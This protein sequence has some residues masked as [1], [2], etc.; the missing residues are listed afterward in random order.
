M[1]RVEVNALI[2]DYGSVRAVQEVSFVVPEGGMTTMLGPSGCGKTTT[3]RCIAGLETATAGRIVIGARTVFEDGRDRVPVEARNLGMV[4][5]SY[6]IWPHMTIARNVAYGLRMRGRSRDEIARRVG[7]ALAL[8]RLADYGERYPGQLSGGQ[9]QRVV[10]ARALAYDPE[11]LLLDEPLANLDAHLREEMRQELKRIQRETGMTMIAVTHDQSEALAL[12]DQIMVMSHGRVIQ[13]GRPEDV[14]RTPRTAEVAHFLGATNQLPAKR[15]DGRWIVDG[16]GP[17]PDHAAPATGADAAQVLFRPSDVVL[18]PADGG[19]GWPGDVVFAQYLGR[20]VQYLI[21]CGGREITV[22]V[23]SHGG[24]F[25]E[26]APV[27]LQVAPGGL[28]VYPE[29]RA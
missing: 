11:L 7:A 10:L 14:F 4:F 28:F 1:S 22:E 26:G 21:R 6:A 12:S 17:L 18:R 20:D 23:P 25:A 16:L 2:K 29:G 15:V 8:V 5:Q 9:M 27:R 24:V 19:E 13:R 3:L